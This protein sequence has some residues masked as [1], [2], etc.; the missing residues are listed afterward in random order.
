MPVTAYKEAATWAALVAEGASAA[1]AA[2]A[3]SGSTIEDSIVCCR[4]SAVFAIDVVVASYSWRFDCAHLRRTRSLTC[5][6]R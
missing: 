2:A 4:L 1:W 3:D 5:F 6:E